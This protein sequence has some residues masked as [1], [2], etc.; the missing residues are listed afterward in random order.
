MHEDVHVALFVEVGV[1]TALDADDVDL[2]TAG[3]GV[4]EHAAGLHAAH[5]GTHEGCALAG[6][7]MEEFYDGVDVVVEIDTKSVFNISRCCH[8]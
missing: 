6:F 5:L 2:G 8:K 7:H 1:G 3:E 4:L